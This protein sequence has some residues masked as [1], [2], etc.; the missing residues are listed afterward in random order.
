MEI[1][2]GSDLSYGVISTK[3]RGSQGWSRKRQV[4]VTWDTDGCN[5]EDEAGGTEGDCSHGP[6]GESGAG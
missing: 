5:G 3:T 1:M 4:E 6:A 2:A